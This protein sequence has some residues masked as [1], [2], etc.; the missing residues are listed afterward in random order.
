MY[1]LSKVKSHSK[2][3]ISQTFKLFNSKKLKYSRTQTLKY[4][5]TQELKLIGDLIEFFFLS[6][7]F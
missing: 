2:F 7:I 5:N 3:Q 6:G 4:S 1:V